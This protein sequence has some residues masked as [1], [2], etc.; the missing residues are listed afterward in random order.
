MNGVD[1]ERRLSFGLV[2]RGAPIPAELAELGPRLAAW[3]YQEL[4]CN[5]GHGRSGLATLAVA[6][7]DTPGMDL[8]VGVVPL[9]ERPIAEIL[10]EVAASGIPHGRLVLGV[11]TGNGASLAAVRDGV[12]ALREALPEVRL[13]IAA[14]GPRMCQL[15]GEIADA[16]LLN[17]AYPERIAW[18]RERVAEGAA[19]AGRPAPR[20]G[21]YVRTAL[22]VAADDMLQAE[23]RRYTT[24]PRPYTRL[25]EE[26]GAGKRGAPGV[27]ATEKSQVPGLLAPYCAVLDSCVVRAL[28]AGP[29]VAELL[30]IAEAAAT[31]RT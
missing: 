8:C 1:H 2:A 26:Q 12:A 22:G 21:C 27:A 4:W 29:S 15:G 11:G 9:S 13:A 7:R 31:L 17:W 16:V 3:G 14:L 6:G 18:S 23:G 20:I 5:D 19:S 24:R 25:F 30:A 28:P 10:D